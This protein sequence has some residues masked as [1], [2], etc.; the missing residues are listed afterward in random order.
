MIW[1]R[2]HMFI[3]FITLILTPMQ[4]KL[5]VYSPLPLKA[6]LQWFYVYSLQSPRRKISDLWF[7]AVKNILKYNWIV[8]LL[9][10]PKIFSGNDTRTDLFTQSDTDLNLRPNR[11]KLFHCGYCISCS[12]YVCVLQPELQGFVGKWS[13]GG[14]AVGT[15]GGGALMPLHWRWCC[16]PVFV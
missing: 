11:G 9:C 16:A 2:L 10:I 5:S 15:E 7:W 1:C 6:D 8:T 3:M 13:G 14:A 4:T 12:L